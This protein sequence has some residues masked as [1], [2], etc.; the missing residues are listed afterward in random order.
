MQNYACC[1][2]KVI[3]RIAIIAV[4]YLW[5]TVSRKYT[6]IYCATALHSGLRQIVNRPEPRKYEAAFNI[7]LPSGWLKIT[8]SGR[9]CSYIAYIELS[10]PYDRVPRNKLMDILKRLGCG[11]ALLL[12]LIAMY[13]ITKSIL[14]MG[15][16][17]AIVGVRQGSPT[18]CFLFILH[19]R[20]KVSVQNSQAGHH[21]DSRHN[22]KVV[23]IHQ[24][25]HYACLLSVL[26][27]NI[28]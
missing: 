4:Q 11:C 16:I 8:A 25:S 15:V 28:Y 18:S 24:L 13:K 22:F 26:L 6:T 9:D 12:A 17:T 2:I 3:K 1:S 19:R 20:S 27:L 23:Y 5:L 10:K 7:L 14:G 21:D